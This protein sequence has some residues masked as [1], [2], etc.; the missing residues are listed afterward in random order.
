MRKVIMVVLVAFVLNV[1]VGFM[2]VTAEEL[3]YYLG[4][5]VNTGKDN[6]FSGSR[7]IDSDDPH[8]GW[9]LGSF[10]TTGFTRQTVDENGHPVFLKTVGDKITLWFE[11]DQDISKLNGNDMLKICGDTNGYDEYFGIPEFESGRGTLIIRKTDYQNCVGEPVV[12]KDYLAANASNT[13]AVE[14][15]LLEEGDYEVALNYEIRKD[16]W[17]I[18]GW[19]TMPSY[20]NYRIYF[21]FSVRNGNCM[22]FP[23]DAVTGSELV[24]TSFTE[25]GFSLDLAR[26]RYLDID[27]RKEVMNETGDGL[28][29]DVR[30]NRPAKDGDKYTE[31]GIYTITVRNRYTDQQ[32]EKRIYVGADDVMKAHV[33]T[34][35]EIS[36]IT[37]QLSMGATVDVD[38]TLKAASPTE[39]PVEIETQATTTPVVTETQ[40]TTMPVEV[41]NQQ[42]ANG[43]V[44]W[45]IAAG[46]LLL[47][48]LALVIVIVLRKKKAAKPMDCA[49]NGGA[50]E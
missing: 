43:I 8:W 18:F 44:V 24:N 17:N 19:H 26:S 21:R 36:E 14:V 9:T 47:G 42:A 35:L 11:L 15:E 5:A 50:E 38:G 3:R 12:Y 4:S 6:G 49:G 23:F 20:F 48:V 32:S 27:I 29:E 28:M 45:V 33:T 22:V 41:E 46:V 30:F 7:A 1:V 34:G 25:N 13:A 10:Y 37:R 40:P 39:P 2:P 31:E 16:N